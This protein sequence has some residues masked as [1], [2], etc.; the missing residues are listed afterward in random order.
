VRD[1]VTRSSNEVCGYQRFSDRSST[2]HS[3]DAT[4]GFT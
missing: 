3:A 4:N 2:A 1:R